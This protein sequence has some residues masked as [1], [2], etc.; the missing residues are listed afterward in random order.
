MSD[1]TITEELKIL[2]NKFVVVQIDMN[3]GNVTFVCHIVSTQTKTIKPLHKV[4]SDDTSFLTSRF[5]LEVNVDLKKL[6]RPFL[7]MGFNCLKAAKSLRGDS[8]LFT[9]HSSGVTGTL[10]I[11]LV[12]IKG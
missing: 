9:I 8:L 7:W 10:L 6:Y 2:H 1:K 11:E 5:N 3:S 4:V 12:R